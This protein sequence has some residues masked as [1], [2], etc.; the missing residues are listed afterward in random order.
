MLRILEKPALAVTFVS[1][2][3]LTTF[4]TAQLASSSRDVGLQETVPLLV[5]Y[6]GIKN[7]FEPGEQ[8]LE[9]VFNPY[10]LLPFGKRWL[11]EVNVEF[12]GVFAHESNEPWKKVF[13]R[14]VEFAQIGFMANRYLTVVGGRFITP[15]GI[16][17]ERV[18]PLWI[19]K[20]QRKP[21]LAEMTTEASNGGMLRGGFRV[22]RGVNM[23]Y[24][25][26]FAAATD[27]A[28]IE[29]TRSAGGR[30]GFYLTKPRLE[31]GG[32]FQRLFQH[33]RLK[34]YGMDVS[35]VPDFAPVELRGE[36]ARNAEQSGYWAETAYRLTRKHE[37][38]GRLEQAFFP[39][40]GESEQRFR[41]GWNY[42]PDDKWKVSFSYGRDYHA[43]ESKGVFTL[44]LVYRLFFPLAPSQSQY[45]DSNAGASQSSGSPS[46]LTEET[47]GPNRMPGTEKMRTFAVAPDFAYRV[48]C[49]RCHAEQKKLPERAAATVLR[50]MRIRAN[51]TSDEAE[52]ILHYLT[53]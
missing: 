1:L 52:A 23:N 19:R 3:L 10:L 8:E 28:P 39:V 51:L 18:Q 31:I 33:Q 16:Y 45:A 38:V 14:K 46:S 44:G 5:G 26:Y 2:L 4:A 27:I 6:G 42:H 53:R 7:T 9:P 17:S 41:F 12:E 48:N 11:A 13:E 20:L 50:H 43:S 30:L 25:G 29:G 24:A 22:G 49:M 21:L 47:L 36:I 40:P 32:S 35:W 15:F 34:T 37:A